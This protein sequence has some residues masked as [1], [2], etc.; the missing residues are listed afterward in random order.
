MLYPTVFS[1]L[2]HLDGIKPH[3]NKNKLF[4]ALAG[5]LLLPVAAFAQSASQSAPSDSDQ[6]NAKQLQTITVTGSALPRVDIETPSPVTVISAQQIERSGL[7]TISDVVRSISADNSGSIPNA[8]GNGFAAGASGVA[9]RGLTVNSTLVLIDGHR[10][11]NYAVTDD[12]QR[13]FVDLNTIPIAAVDRIEVLKDGASSL[14]GAD[15]IAG[16]VNVILKKNFSGLEGTADVGTSAHGGGA[17]KKGTIIAGGGDLQTDHYNAY[18]S[19]NYEKDQAIYNRDRGFPYNTNDLTSIGGQNA[20]VGLPGHSSGS[21]VGSVTP[22]QLATPGNLNTGVPNTGALVQPLGICNQGTQMVTNVAGTTCSQNTVAQ[23]G[24]GQLPL[25]QGGLYG[26]FTVKLNDDTTA[27]MS[28]SYAESKTSLIAAPA[29]IETSSPVNTSHIALPITLPNGQLNPNNPFAAQGQYALINYAFGDIPAGNDYDNHNLRL[30]GDVAGVLGDWNYDST[31]VINHTW[32]NT[33]Q[34]GLLNYTA[35]NN[36]VVNGTYNFI[37]PSANTAAERAALAPGYAKTSTSDMDSLDLA[38]NR[39]LWDLPGGALGVATG[40]QFRHEAQNDPTLNPGAEFQGLGNAMTKGTRDVSGAYVEFDAPVLSSLE[41][42][43]SGR[44][45]HY[46]DIGNG[47]TPKLGLKWKPLDW[48]AVRGTYSKGLRA[49]G[50]AENGSSSSEG[51]TTYGSTALPASFVAAHGGADN[52]YNQAYSLINAVAANPNIKPEK[53]TNYTLGLV[54][55]PTSWL[56]ASVDYYNIK[57][58]NVITTPD[59]SSALADYFA[60][61][62]LPAGVLVIPDVADPLHPNAQARPAEV[63]GEY[64][65][66]NSLKTTGI[67]LDVQAHFD[68]ANNIHWISEISGTDIFGWR[69]VLP[70]GEVE[71]FAGTHGPYAL[72]SGAGTPRIRGSFANTLVFGAATITGTLYYT[73]GMSNVAADVGSNCLSVLPLS[74]HVGSFTDFDLTGSYSINSHIDITASIMNAFDRKAPLDGA[75]YAGVNYN[76]TFDQQ[77]FIG[78]FYNLGVKFK[79]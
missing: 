33:T 24:E 48:V 78:R 40:V 75:N 56:S 58:T 32:L 29:Q 71:S 1:A 69:L 60:G 6:S 19:V 44:F 42:D 23:Y 34:F 59:T 68:F 66:A 49:P 13:S 21:V 52:P 54:F 45:D 76:P 37:N 27:Y 15:A 41:V 57:K 14:Y 8:F 61:T 64:I 67:D 74:C 62:P 4:L 22:G 72:S 18:F 63:I 17:T 31:V 11:A 55:Q 5:A 77:G 38:A 43:V 70:D 7:T 20:N 65:N 2:F 79:L 36:A 73:S 10:A 30:V 16:V 26:R 46:T 35:L 12:G 28:A 53:A 9:L 51:F 25:E 50:F 39:Q 3:M 47:F